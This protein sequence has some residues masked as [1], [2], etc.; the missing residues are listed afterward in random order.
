MP[1]C[2][3]MIVGTLAY[4]SPEQVLG[5]PPEPG[6]DIYSLGV[7]L[8]ELVTGKKPFDAGDPMGTAMA[9]L[10]ER[11]PSP[12]EVNPDVPIEVSDAI[13]R[14]MVPEPEKRYQSAQSLRKDLSDLLEQV[15]SGRH[16][17]QLPGTI[18]RIFS[19]KMVRI[20]FG[21]AVMALIL[22]AVFFGIRS[23]WGQKSGTR[24]GSHPIIAVLPFLNL[25]GN[26]SDEALCAS[27][28]TS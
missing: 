1:D 22:A 13:C 4:M 21:I 16:A 25:S 2:S 15:T 8:Y 3:G 24:G 6:H 27:L 9:I 18:R 7:V 19:R 12:A 26:N 28:P 14:A 17:F 11:P 10:K 5:K 20:G 23:R